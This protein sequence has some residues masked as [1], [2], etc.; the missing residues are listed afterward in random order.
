MTLLR[1]AG[2]AKLTADTNKT[3]LEPRQKQPAKQQQTTNQRCY[4]DEAIELMHERVADVAE[5]HEFHP[6]EDQNGAQFDLNNDDNN[7]FSN[8]RFNELKLKVAEQDMIIKQLTTR[9]NFVLSMLGADDVTYFASAAT[10][11]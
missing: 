3:A 1:P 4:N 8:K 9:L 2:K 11:N 10:D 7:L 5:S 6:C